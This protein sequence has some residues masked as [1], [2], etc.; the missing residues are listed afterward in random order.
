MAARKNLLELTDATFRRELE[1]V[2]IALVFFTDRRMFGYHDSTNRRLAELIRSR[3]QFFLADIEANLELGREYGVC[4]LNSYYLLRR[5]RLLD[6]YVSRGSSDVVDIAVWCDAVLDERPRK[7]RY[8]EYVTSKV[9]SEMVAYIEEMEEEETANTRRIRA[10][11]LELDQR[12]NGTEEQVH[13][14]LWAN[15]FLLD[16]FYDGGYVMS[17]LP[18]GIKYVSDFVV[19]GYRNWTN[20]VGIH[21]TLIELE[22]PTGKLFTKA[23][24]PAAVLTH[25]LRQVQDWKAWLARNGD[26]FRRTVRSLLVEGSPTE[27]LRSSRSLSG[28]YRDVIIGA[29]DD[30]VSYGFTVIAGRRQPMSLADRIR[31]DEMNNSLNGIRIMTYDALVEGW[32]RRLGSVV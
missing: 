8:M 27:R 23:G 30:H 17:K 29:L 12:L 4:V 10:S 18:L 13:A 19:F 20:D 25:A 21:A 14:H 15:A 5:G 6:S 2:E 28:F 16:L 32:M 11:L 7:R 9:A 24:D 22:R 31:L 26:Y 3:G 1:D